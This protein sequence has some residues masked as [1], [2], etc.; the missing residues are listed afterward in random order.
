[1]GM[2]TLGW[3]RK[4]AVHR[5]VKMLKAS[6]S[7]HVAVDAAGTVAVEELGNQGGMVASI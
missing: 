5:E 7:E 6:A 3:R 2:N 1:M 4:K